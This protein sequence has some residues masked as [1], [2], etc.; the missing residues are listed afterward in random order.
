MD[1]TRQD[2]VPLLETISPWL[3][4]PNIV[5][6]DVDKK[7]ID[8]K[9]TEAWAIVVY[10]VKKKNFAE[11]S[12]D[13]FPV[14][15]E[16]ELHI[17][18]PEGG[19]RIT[20]VP[21]DIV[22]SGLIRAYALDGYQRPCQGGYQISGKQIEG[23][24]PKATLGVNIVWE[25]KYRLLTCNHGISDNGE[26]KTVWQPYSVQGWELATITGYTPVITYPNEEQP[27]PQENFQDLA[28]CD[29]DENL[30][31]STIYNIGIPKGIRKPVVGEIVRMVGMQT[32]QVME[33]TIQSTDAKVRFELKKN[34]WAWFNKM[35]RLNKS[36]AQPGDS[37][38]AYVGK[39]N[40]V[41]GIN[42]SGN[43]NFTYGCALKYD[44]KT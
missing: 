28:W 20:N 26:N 24:S 17:A 44:D 40:C 27:F 11:F 38:A 21:T 7:I 8:G 6:L 34:Q 39:D 23:K 30:G 33:A 25:G 1:L 3:S 5:G 2:V 37:G 42:V 19:Y 9:E 41:V 4:K 14:P 18:L 31:S 12:I 15:N 10:V 35:I 29:I 22:E 13:D 36:I 43:D 32:A 16:I